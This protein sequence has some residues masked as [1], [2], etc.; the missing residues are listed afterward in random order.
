[1]VSPDNI[2][3]TKRLVLNTTAAQAVGSG[4]VSPYINSTIFK[5]DDGTTRTNDGASDYIAYCFHSVEGYSKVGLYTGNGSIDGAFIYTG[6]RPRWTMVKNLASAEGYTGWVMQ[7]NL[8]APYNVVTLG[9]MLAADTSY[10]E[11]TR[12]QGSASTLNYYD[13][14]SNG[15]KMRN[16][17]YEINQA[18]AQY[19]YLAFAESPFKTADAR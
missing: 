8:R 7:D 15:F 9:T 12:T 3:T 18:D 6:F 19:L 16:T 5:L 1:M 10:V 4:L 11:G 14:L 17:S 13:M 2:S